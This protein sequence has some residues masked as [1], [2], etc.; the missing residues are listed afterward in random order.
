MNREKDKVTIDDVKQAMNQ[1]YVLFFALEDGDESK[2]LGYSSLSR[3]YI[4]K[5]WLH[6]VYIGS[7]INTA[8]ELYNDNGVA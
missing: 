3:S 4:V 6:T 1:D 2:S 8:I 5:K 7:S